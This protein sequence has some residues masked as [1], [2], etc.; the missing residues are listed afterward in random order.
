LKKRKEKGINQNSDHLL[1]SNFFLVT[2]RFLYEKRAA[3]PKLVQLA[4]K[5]ESFSQSQRDINATFLLC[6]P[7]KDFVS[8]SILAS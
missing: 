1:I 4:G 8:I 6:M 2:P 5:R 3:I 7:S